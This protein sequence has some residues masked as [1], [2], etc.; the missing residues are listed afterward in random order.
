M[1]MLDT[2]KI[3]EEYTFTLHTT[4]EIDQQNL[5]V[6]LFHKK[7]YPLIDESIKK[8]RFSSFSGKP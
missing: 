5:R 1:S 8:S 7:E 3:Y 6:A 2:M 4:F